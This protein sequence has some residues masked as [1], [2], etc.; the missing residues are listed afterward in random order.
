ML[1][2]DAIAV[3]E[4]EER[5]DPSGASGA[6]LAHVVFIVLMIAVLILWALSP[7]CENDCAGP[8]SLVHKLAYL[9]PGAIVFVA[10]L[11]VRRR[12]GPASGRGLWMIGA[13]VLFHGLL[14]TL[15]PNN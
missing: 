11:D 6:A 2:A 7:L 1:V 5:S 14:I 9:I 12:W 8:P 4:T 3:P 15:W 13:V 10:G